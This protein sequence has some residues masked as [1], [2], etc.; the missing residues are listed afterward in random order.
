[1][2]GCY[3][4]GVL[5]LSL[6]PVSVMAAAMCGQDFCPRVAAALARGS[7]VRVPGWRG[8]CSFLAVVLPGPGYLVPGANT[9]TWGFP[10]MVCLVAAVCRNFGRA[11]WARWE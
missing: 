9:V 7:T 2:S 4:L 6:G 3:G 8:G 11:F 5:F 10:V 1:M